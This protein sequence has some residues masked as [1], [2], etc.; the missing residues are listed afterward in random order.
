[1]SFRQNLKDWYIRYTE[2]KWTVGVAEYDPD[3]I[4]DI[5]KKLNIHWIKGAP[6]SSWFA[7]PF[8]LS[9]TDDHVCLLVEE[10][11]YA[12]KKGRISKLVVNRHTWKLERIIP[13]ID[14]S[15]HLSFP[16]Y[17]RENGKVYIYPEGTNSGK[18]TLYE[19]DERDGSAV[20]VKVLS[21]FPLAD[22]VIWN[23]GTK[24]YILATTSPKDNGKVLDFYPLMEG[25]AA[26]PEK[27]YQFNTYMARNAG[28]PFSVNGRR[29]RPAQDCTGH[30][31]SCVVLQEIVDDGGDI[32]FKEIRRLHS[33]LL[34]YHDGFHTFNVFGERLAAV[35]A[36]G[37]RHGLVAQIIYHIRERF[38]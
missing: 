22:A 14:I 6:K 5:N 21:N 37:F 26:E 32:S 27:R 7:D 38:R 35:D 13:V 19:Y 2:F 1:M 16:A 18:L 8:I 34:L 23:F 17:Y 30:Y 31:G 11:L 25:P 3:T 36:Q 12:S 29:I 4:L 15:T 28:I 24:D 9:E 33:P 10:Y 20:P